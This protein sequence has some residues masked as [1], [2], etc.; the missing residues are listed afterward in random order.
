MSDA[1]PQSQV[2]AGGVTHC[3]HLF[4]IQCVFFGKFS[5]VIGG[6]GNIEK[7]PGPAASR[8]SNTPVFDVPY[9][10]TFIAKSPGERPH[11]VSVVKQMEQMSISFKGVFCSSVFI[12]R[13]MPLIVQTTFCKGVSFDP[14]SVSQY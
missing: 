12:L 2:T 1:Q 13:S 5:H 11:V 6:S 3:Y 9:S 10:V 14:L 8:M 7:G 4:H